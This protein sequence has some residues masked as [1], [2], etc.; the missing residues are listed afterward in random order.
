MEFLI[1]IQQDFLNSPLVGGRC[2]RSEKLKGSHY[3]SCSCKH[4][5]RIGGGGTLFPVYI[6]N[7]VY[8]YLSVLECRVAGNGRIRAIMQELVNIGNKSHQPWPDVDQVFLQ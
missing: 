4:L 6:N 7:L 3:Q 8:A 5:G 1:T 2:A